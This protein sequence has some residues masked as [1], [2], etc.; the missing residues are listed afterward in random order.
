MNESKVK[1]INRKAAAN[2]GIKAQ[3]VNQLLNRMGVNPEALKVGDVIKMPDVI[4]LADGS[5]SAAMVNG[6]PF[7]QVVVTVNG[8]ARN[9]AVS[10]FNRVFVDRETRARTTP[11]DLLD[12]A[13]KAKAVFKHFEGGTVDEGLQQL[14]GKELEVKRIE[15]FESVTRDG[16]PMNVNVTAIIER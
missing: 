9:L 1:E 3:T 4:S 8:E 14:K 10:T 6:N 11:V 5:L 2:L 15:T 16:A 7:L 12:E 13:D